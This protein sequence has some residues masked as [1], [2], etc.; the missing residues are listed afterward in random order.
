MSRNAV[1]V[2]VVGLVL[3]ALCGPPVTEGGV[4]SVTN[5]TGVGADLDLYPANPY[6]HKLDFPGDSQSAPVNGTQLSAVG[7]GAGVDPLTGNAYSLTMAA[8]SDWGTGST[9]VIHDFIHNGGQPANSTATLTL[10]GLAPGLTYDARLYYRDF[11]TRPNTVTIDTDGV[12]GAEFTGTLDQQ[13]ASAQSYWSI[14]YQADSPTVTINF[15]QDLANNSWHHYAVTNE[16]YVAPSALFSDNF[17]T[18]SDNTV[19]SFNPLKEGRQG[20]S[21][22]LGGSQLGPINWVS[23]RTFQNITGDQVAMQNAG[24]G[25]LHL[26]HNFTD[27]ALTA[28]GGFIIEYDFSPNTDAGSDW[29]AINLGLTFAEA[30]NDVAPHITQ[31]YTDFGMLIRGNGGFQVFDS[32]VAVG[33]GSMGHLEDN[34]VLLM[35]QTGGFA[36][37]DM[38]R[39]DA[40]YNGALID[41]N[42]AAAG[43]QLLINW[44][45]GGENFIEFEVNDSG[46][47]FDNLVIRGLPEPGTMTLL[48]FGGLGL[49]ARRRRR[50]GKGAGHRAAALVALLALGMLLAAPAAQAGV[51]AQYPLTGDADSGISAY[52]TYTHALNFN[53]TPNVTVNGAVFTGAGG[54]NP[55]TNNYSVS[56]LGAT[57]NNNAPP[58]T[59][60]M[61]TMLDDF[62]YGGNPGVVT[63]N[64]LRVGEKYTT[65]FYNTAFGSPGSRFQTITTSNGDS[66]HFDENFTGGRNGNRLVY[67]FTAQSPTMVYTITPDIPGN[68]FH[69]Y[70]AS[71]RH[72]GWHSVLTDNYYAPSNPDTQDVNFNLAA[73]QGGSLVQMLGPVA[74]SR[75]GNIQV[76]NNTGGLDSGNYLLSGGGRASLNQDFGGGLSAG[77]QLISFDMAAQINNPSGSQW[78]GINLGLSQAD[79][80]VGINAAVPHLGILF[81]GNGL[82]EIWDGNTR[83]NDPANPPQWGPSGEGNLFHHIEILLTDSVD[84][85]PFDGAGVMDV[86]VFADGLSVFTWSKAGGYA[87]NYISFMA[88]GVAGIDNLSI[89]NTV[90]EPGTMT[91]LALG[92]MGLLARRRRRRGKGTGHRGAALVALLALGMLFGTMGVS[93]ATVILYSDTFTAPNGTLLVGRTPEVNAAVAGATYDQHNAAWEKDIQSN[94]A[95]IGADTG[96]SLPLGSSGSYVKPTKIRISATLNT[97]TLNGSTTPSNTGNQRGVG[98]GFYASTGSPATETDFRGLLLG[99]DGRLIVAR[100][101]VPGADRA[102][103]VAQIATGLSTAVPHTVSYE[104]DTVTGDVSRIILDGVLQADMA[105]TIFNSSTDRA[106][107]FGSAN[108]GGT[109]GRVDDLVVDVIYA[110]PYTISGLYNTGVDDSGTPLADNVGDPHYDLISQPESGSLTETTIPADGYPIPPWLGND[111]DSRWIAPNEDNGTGPAGSYTY[112][113]TFMLPDTADLD[114]ALISGGWA[115]DDGGA[116]TDI[117][118]NGVSIG[119]ISGGFG[120]LTNFSIASGFVLGT[121]TL[122]FLVNNGAVGPTGLRVDNLTG[123]YWDTTPEPGTMTLL[124]FGGM[125]LLARRRRRRGKGAGQTHV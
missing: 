110:S 89:S 49:L 69:L 114:A 119:Q 11:G 20:S 62:I 45:A 61:L 35:V 13:P 109:T 21:N 103:F 39:L 46:F 16:K 115:S 14:V 108:S 19:D 30:N 1:F 43:T 7:A 29:M 78:L 77:G 112:R 58:V 91:L 27:P 100:D 99:T 47:G 41:L 54:A 28:G 68:S 87:S 125:G 8:P 93:R 124:A 92:G 10:S 48:A 71:N 105:T 31:G 86:E 38:A 4:I 25:Q 26:N 63:L 101:D 67:A 81:R 116:L 111:A 57:F 36:A 117:L 113:T 74:Y 106:G 42:G 79:Q 3:A 88:F 6:T 104:I 72:V 60:D 64:N 66:I 32:G 44:D 82:M 53:Y 56:G 85:N 51:F 12:A 37:G 90:P 97:G 120:G 123:T 75:T 107:F 95:R 9:S 122:D 2:A 33:S 23:K 84:S 70:A 40:W 94:Q 34:H 80:L 18:G 76:G 5:H 22:G 102:G 50:R 52:G 121:N 55:S 59:G 98:L 83:V 73:R 65:T 15:S 17:N 24:T 118:I 96:V